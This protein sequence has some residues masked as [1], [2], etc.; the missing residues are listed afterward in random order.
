MV[1]PAPQALQSDSLRHIRAALLPW[2][3]TPIGTGA[4]RT[5]LTSTDSLTRKL[6]AHSEGQFAVQVLHQGVAFCSPGR[7]ITSM[8]HGLYWQREVQLLGHQE[9]WV[10]AL[11]FV[12]ARHRR[13]CTRLHLL[14]EQ[15]L[16]AFLFKQPD[17]QRQQMDYAATP[18]GLARRAR[19]SIGHQQIILVE[20][21]LNQ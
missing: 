13:L 10:R 18:W 5:W 6:V 16:G 21:F 20:L 15:P 19:F 1:N 11:T 12:P 3:S 17:L 2:Q 14:G 9:P 8:H 4:A 7:G